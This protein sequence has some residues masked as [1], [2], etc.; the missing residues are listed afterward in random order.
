MRKL[1]QICYLFKVFLKLFWKCLAPL[2]ILSP[3]EGLFNLWVKAHLSEASA[4]LWRLHKRSQTLFQMT[5]LGI[6]KAT[7]LC[8]LD[9][10]SPRPTT[11]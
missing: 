3:L 7:W 10:L 6:L 1:P 11:P 9:C 2:I 8:L 5:T 4:T